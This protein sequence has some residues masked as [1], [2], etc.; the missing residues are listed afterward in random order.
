MSA[1]T[2]H[3]AE[4]AV[5]DPVGA[6]VRIGLAEFAS[7]QLETPGPIFER[8]RREAATAMEW[9][10]LRAAVDVARA[11]APANP[12]CAA[13]PRALG[14]LVADYQLELSDVFM[15]ALA[16]EVEASHTID[17]AVAELQGPGGLSWPSMHLCVAMI[18][19]LFDRPALTAQHLH[20]G[21][22]VRAGILELTGEGPVP[23]R[24]V[25][26]APALWATLQDRD[27][28]WP[29]TVP[30]APE[31]AAEGSAPL[32]AQLIA[33]GGAFA[34]GTV[35]G[36]VLRGSPGTGRSAAAAALGRRSGLRPVAVP[37][38]SWQE[39]PALRAA[40]RYGGWLAVINLE[41]GPGEVWRMPG[42]A[43]PPSPVAAVVGSDGAVQ[44]D[45]LVE[46]DVTL[47]DADERHAIWSRALGADDRALVEQAARE[48]LIGAPAIRSIAAHARL[49]A[50]G[51]GETLAPDHVARARRRLG[52]DRLRLLAQ[53][54]DR[55]VGDGDLVVAERVR[56][57]LRL[58]IAR[59]RARERLWQGL[60]PTLRA[61][62]SVGARAL[63]VGESG[64]GKTLA[65]SL[66]ATELGAP[67][68]RVDIAA[69]M[70]KYVGESEKNLAAVLD[71]AAAHDVILLFDEADSLFGRRSEARETGER[72]ANM[73]TNYLLTRI[74][75]HPGIVVLTSNS[76]ERID[77]AFTRR[78][79]AIVEFPAP[80][81]SERLALWRAHLGDNGP[82]DEAYAYLASYCDLAGGHIRNAV[83]TAA[84]R[85]AGAP[86]GMADLVHGLDCEYR[87]LGRSLPPNLAQLR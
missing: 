40:A 78:L 65:A 45:G 47:P 16:G 17:L 29:G 53:P 39:Q 60:G 37:A 7:R 35:R 85:A 54:I 49:L 44:G 67:L 1:T 33:L 74:E 24:S 75:S 70:N 3:F 76:R 87:K 62:R 81:Q 83:L 36:A 42:A 11:G 79:D 20:D 21:P 68:Y 28:L 82:G 61:T 23:L 27:G 10:M 77:S 32:A 51:A 43:E 80:G 63:F 12:S 15:L 13:L 5:P 71:Q 18:G 4:T 6:L 56:E 86:I 52:A 41:L 73:L 64:T 30:L 34:S 66:V 22:L 8:L 48:Q 58:F 55:R 46:L 14:R 9:Q 72:Y 69:V 2:Q 31:A 59:C 19:T 26:T 57:E 84:T 50:E 38:A 25:R